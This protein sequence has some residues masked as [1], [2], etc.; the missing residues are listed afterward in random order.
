MEEL[1][2]ESKEVLRRS[3]DPSYYRSTT[4][5]LLIVIINT[6][7]TIKYYSIFF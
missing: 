7:S 4:R 3:K 1:L 6:S 5:V 2:M